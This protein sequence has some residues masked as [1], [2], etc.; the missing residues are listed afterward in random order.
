M[1][2]YLTGPFVGSARGASSVSTA[3]EISNNRVRTSG[4]RTFGAVISEC[5]IRRPSLKV[6]MSHS[7]S[8][9][10]FEFEGIHNFNGSRSVLNRM[11]PRPLAHTKAQQIAIVVH[12]RFATAAPS[13]NTGAR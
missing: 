5:S 4:C 1:S 8:A 12:G 3:S 11:N 2:E 9:R 6:L 7:V 13:L 10:N